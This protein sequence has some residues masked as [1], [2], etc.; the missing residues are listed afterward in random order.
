MDI[1]LW[2]QFPSTAARLSLRLSVSSKLEP[3][4]TI[5]PSVVAANAPM[6]YVGGGTPCCAC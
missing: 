5:F 6:E 2:V 1:L 4:I 3:L